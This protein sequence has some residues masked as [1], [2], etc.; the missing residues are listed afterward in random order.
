MALCLRESR[1]VRIDARKEALN[2]LDS[3]RTVLHEIKTV[4][5]GNRDCLASSRLRS[6]TTW[7][8]ANRIMEFNALSRDRIGAADQISY[9]HQD[10]D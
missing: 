2:T 7:S 6:G 8:L 4:Q 10:Q 3:A 5:D 1:P 9:A